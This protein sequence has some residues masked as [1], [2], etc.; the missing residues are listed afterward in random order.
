MRFNESVLS[1]SLKIAKPFEAEENKCKKITPLRR[2]THKRI[3]KR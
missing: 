2:F 3:K 1:A